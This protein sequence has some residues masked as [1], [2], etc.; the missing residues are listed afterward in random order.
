MPGHAH[1]QPS[2]TNLR[3]TLT[4]LQWLEGHDPRQG[5]LG[6]ELEGEEQAVEQ[7]LGWEK[8]TLKWAFSHL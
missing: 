5:L 6:E 3:L 1:L 4:M 8:E 2:P 7:A